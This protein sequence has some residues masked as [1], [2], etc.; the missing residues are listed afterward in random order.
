[1][2]LQ[3]AFNRFLKLWGSFVFT[4]VSVLSF[5]NYF[6][7][8]TFHS[9]LDLFVFNFLHEE[10]LA[11]LTTVWQDYPVVLATL[12]V[13]M[14]ST[15][16]TLFWGW[17]NRKLEQSQF[18]SRLSVLQSIAL[19][20]VFIL[21]FS[22][23]ARGSLTSRY[24]LRR[25]NAQVSV[26]ENINHVVLNAP[27]AM[28]YAWSDYKKAL[29]FKAVDSQTGKALLA[30]TGLTTLYAQTPENSFLKHS[31][32][33]VALFIMESMGT[34][35]LSFDQK[36]HLDLLGAFRPHYENDWVFT[37]FLS[38]DLHTIQSVSQLLFL[39][40]VSQIS[41]STARLV[42]LPGTPFETYKKAG[43]RTVFV[44]S[45]T[46]VWKNLSEYLPI[47]YV[48]EVYDKTHLMDFYHLSDSSVWGVEDHFAFDF[49]QLMS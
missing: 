1:M 30:Q 11:V 27:M 18:L 39:S 49:M 41:T 26:I 35:L 34:N 25:N 6:Y 10:P 20:V 22:L 12:M 23:L 13:L 5:I 45:G 21:L 43:Y 33:N 16:L 28:Y 9:P 4:I 46:T 19:G 14:A 48:D 40:P 44:T 7:I 17:S 24:P 31:K 42:S 3:T 38:A 8:Q 47:Q 37:R 15:L 36:D 32:P 2:R 29:T